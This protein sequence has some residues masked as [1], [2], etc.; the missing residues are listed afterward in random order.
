MV[1]V[2][3]VAMINV[4]VP[5]NSITL[6]QKKKTLQ[7][8]KRGTLEVLKEINLKLINVFLCVLIVTGKFMMD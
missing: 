8:V 4:S 3:F 6:I 7:S 5:S 1:S 2:K